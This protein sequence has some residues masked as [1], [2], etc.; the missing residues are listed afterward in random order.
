MAEAFQRLFIDPFALPRVSEGA[1]VCM[2]WRGLV[3]V[4]VRPSR[5]SATG[6]TKG[7]GTPF[8]VCARLLTA[9]LRCTSLWRCAGLPV[10]IA[11]A[12]GPLT[13]GPRGVRLTHVQEAA[14]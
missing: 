5:R 1:G 10:G 11:D 13:Q 14:I 8:P 6:T 2:V 12:Q 4:S 9:R 7:R 3:S